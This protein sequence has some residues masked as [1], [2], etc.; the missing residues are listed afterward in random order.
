MPSLVD[1]QQLLV[2]HFGYPAFR[3]AQRDVVRS[4]LGGDDVLA[5][6]PTGAGKSVCF[7][8][9][10]LA[11]DGLTVVVSP[12]VSL[13]QDQVAAARTRG[14]AASA[15]HSALSD[16]ERRDVLAQLRERSLRL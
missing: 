2:R 1:A 12:L 7:Q 10:A 3:R 9:P 6:L 13:M 5:V 8:I 16:D 11:L 4:V 14:I 15:L